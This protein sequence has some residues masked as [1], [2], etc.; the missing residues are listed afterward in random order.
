M[1]KTQT[2]MDF[3]IHSIQVQYTQC[4]SMSMAVAAEKVGLPTLTNH[5][6]RH[7]FA[8]FLGT[9]GATYMDLMDLDGWKSVAMVRR[10]CKVVD[11]RLADVMD[12]FNEN[13][14]EQTSER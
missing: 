13:G 14:G 1:S 6:M 2:I 10:Y 5:M 11:E 7:I 4:F 8:I 9:K 3:L 12:A